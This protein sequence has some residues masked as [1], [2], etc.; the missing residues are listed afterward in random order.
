[1]RSQENPY[2]PPPSNIKKYSK[3]GLTIMSKKQAV[4]DSREPDDIKNVVGQELK[5]KNFEV[6]IQEEAQGDFH[7]P[8][9][10]V[11]IERKTPS[12]L[13]QSI[14]DRRISEQAD[15]MI[16]EH[17]HVY[18][19]IE[20][21]PFN[22]TH[23]DLNHNSIRGQLISLAAKRG[24]KILPTNDKNGTAFTVRRLFQRYKDG[25]HKTNT[26]YL[27]THDTGEV[28][29]V[30]LA[31]LTQINGLSKSKAEN[32]LEK[33]DGEFSSAYSAIAGG[34][35]HLLRSNLEEID[36]IGPKTSEKIVNALK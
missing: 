15:R 24:I 4:I 36:G 30:K 7:Y 2:I 34:K 10:D 26:E 12:D 28:E 21:D 11:V 13:A 14:Q 22:L 31:M 1:M 18:L 27:K 19:I 9:Q 33:L 5:D 20:G 17:D 8:H 29:N 3:K 25:D 23:T 32:V 16:A 35:T 6:S